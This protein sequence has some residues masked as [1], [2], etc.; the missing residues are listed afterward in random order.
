MRT[1]AW[2]AGLALAGVLAGAAGVAAAE[3]RL[4]VR[5]QDG[6]LSVDLDRARA[7]D[8]LAAIAVAAELTVR[9]DQSL[10]GVPLT[11][12]FEAVPL[13]RGLR[14]LIAQLQTENFRIEYAAAAGA[15]RIVRVDILAASGERTV[16][17]FR[18]GA[19]PGVASTVRLELDEEGVIP[20]GIRR[21]M[22]QGL[23]PG[24]QRRQAKTGRLPGSVTRV[25]EGLRLKME[26]GEPMPAGSAWKLER[27]LQ[28]EGAG[29]TDGTRE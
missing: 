20:R 11:S 24:E 27:A 23:T 6:R 29:A 15:P 1:S 5:V 7:G 26:R 25:P 12:R 13:E 19:P 2:V 22:E 28:L 16:Q 9:L 21:Q 10:L 14:R 4:D 18:A 8:V 17:E 3:G